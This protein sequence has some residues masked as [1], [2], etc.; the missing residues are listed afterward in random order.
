MPNKL[1]E[2][3]ENFKALSTLKKIPFIITFSLVLITFI[4]WIYY[5]V[6]PTFKSQSAFCTQTSK[7][8]SILADCLEY[9]KRLHMAKQAWAILLTFSAIL[10]P[11]FYFGSIFIYQF[12]FGEVE[13]NPL[14]IETPK[15]EEKK[16][17]EEVIKTPKQPKKS[18]FAKLP[19]IKRPGKKKSEQHHVESTGEISF[20]HPNQKEAEPKNQPK[21]E[22][23]KSESETKTSVIQKLPEAQ[24]A[25]S[26]KA[27]YMPLSPLGEE[28]PERYS[29]VKPWLMDEPPSF[30]TIDGKRFKEV[31]QAI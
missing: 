21:P 27:W 13:E 22:V 14:K 2:Q 3:F 6:D 5:L 24:T 16:K 26:T 19:K 29:S 11:M 8:L 1:L 17:V 23:F 31:S 30:V 9:P 10:F 7:N 12:L 20:P 18:I 25:E 4:L 28:E 15:V